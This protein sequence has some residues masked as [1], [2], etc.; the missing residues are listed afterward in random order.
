MRLPFRAT[1][2]KNCSPRCPLR[3]MLLLLMQPHSGL[4]TP[5]CPFQPSAFSCLSPTVPGFSTLLQA[6]STPLLAT[7]TAP[8]PLPRLILSPL[9]LRSALM[10]VLLVSSPLPTCLPYPPTHSIMFASG[11]LQTLPTMTRSASSSHA[12]PRLSVHPS[13]LVVKLL[14]ATISIMI[15]LLPPLS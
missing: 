4:L 12:T 8:S 2:V 14:I 9:P 11:G 6:T 3:C 1:S 13:I 10:V 15:P 5:P 7:P